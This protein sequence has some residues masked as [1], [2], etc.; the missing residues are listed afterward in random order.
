M[1]GRGDRC[2]LISLCR[3]LILVGFSGFSDVVLWMGGAQ[4]RSVR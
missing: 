2:R 4:G 1:P 3:A